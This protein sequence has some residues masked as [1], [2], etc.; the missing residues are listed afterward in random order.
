MIKDVIA[1]EENCAAVYFREEE[2][3]F[4]TLDQ[5]KSVF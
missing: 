5:Y 4:R 3:V 2:R 1:E